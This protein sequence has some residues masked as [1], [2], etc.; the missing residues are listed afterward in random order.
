MNH[1]HYI[2][3]TIKKKISWFFSREPNGGQ[4]WNA[5]KANSCMEL[6]LIWTKSESETHW[7]TRGSWAPESPP[8]DRTLSDYNSCSS[9]SS[10]WTPSRRNQSPRPPTTKTK[11]KNL[12]CIVLRE[13]SGDGE[14][15]VR[16]GSPAR[17]GLYEWEFDIAA[18]RSPW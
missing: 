15:R 16:R 8:C 10:S 13:A 18:E 3:N 17:R 4:N 7:C 12:R 5:L 1:Y 14:L 11:K 9:L 6:N 2:W